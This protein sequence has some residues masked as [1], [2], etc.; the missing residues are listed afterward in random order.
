MRQ[1]FWTSLFILLTFHPLNA[2][3]MLFHVNTAS[4]VTFNPAFAGRG[5]SRDG[6]FGRLFIA[7]QKSDFQRSNSQIASLDWHSYR[8]GGGLALIVEQQDIANNL[9]KLYTLK[10]IYNYV[11]PITKNLLIK[12]A[13]QPGYEIK[14]LNPERLSE[15]QS[16]YQSLALHPSLYD[17]IF[18]NNHHSNSKNYFTLGSGI[19]VQKQRLEFGLA[20]QNINRPNWSFS[21]NVVVRKSMQSTFHIQYKFF[22]AKKFDLYAKSLLTTQQSAQLF[23]IGLQFKSKHWMAGL[24]LNQY[25]CIFFNRDYLLGTL[26]YTY[27]NFQLRYG[28]ELRLDKQSIPTVNNQSLSLQVQFQ[29]SNYTVCRPYFRPYRF[30]DITF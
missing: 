6:N 14:S 3:E 8:L 11:L 15:L 1:Q 20:F 4:P 13:I 24:S 16:N 30:N 23:N 2:Q 10:G 12:W 21:E 9:I 5:I 25:Q 19:L 18:E 26:G 17:S 27:R 29:M 22:A 7:S 28:Y